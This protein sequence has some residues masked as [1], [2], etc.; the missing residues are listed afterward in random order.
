MCPE[1]EQEDLVGKFSGELHA[2][3]LGLSSNVECLT[4]N[5]P[6]SVSAGAVAYRGVEDAERRHADLR[7][8]ARRGGAGSPLRSARNVEYELR[9]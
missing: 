1:R 2:R 8:E 4:P 3:A 9:H 7:Q 6:L 5:Y